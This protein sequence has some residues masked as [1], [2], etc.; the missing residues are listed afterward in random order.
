MSHLLANLN[1]RQ[2]E[3]VMIDGGPALILAGPGSG[4]TRVLTHRIA[5]LIHQLNVDPRSIMAVTFTNKAATEMRDR[6][7][8]LL[9]QPIK[10]LVT[11]G[12]FHAICARILRREGQY[13]PFGDRY[14][15]YDT[16]D[17][18]AVVKQA[19]SE[20]NVDPKK[21]TPRQVLGKIS[22]AKNELITPAMFKTLDY[23][24]EVVKQVYTRYQAI[25]LDNNA[26]DFDDLLMQTV[27]LLQDDESIRYKYQMLVQYLLI[28]EFQDTNVAQYEF[29]RLMGAPQQNIFV[30]GDEDQ[31]VYAFRGADYRNV[32]RFRADYPDAQVVLLEQN[33][34]STQIVLDAAR[35]VI[36]RNPNRTPKR[37][38]TDREGGAQI[39]VFEAYNERMEAEYITEQIDRLARRQK[40]NY[41]DFAVMYRT[42]AQSRAI[43]TAFVQQG[44]PYRMV[45]GVGF[46][47][48]REVRDLIAYLRVVDNANDKVSFARIINVPRRSIG[49]K[50]LHDFQMWASSEGGNYQA[51]LIRVMNGESPLSTRLVRPLSEFTAQLIKWQALAGDGRLLDCLDAIIGDI[52]YRWYLQEI[53]DSDEQAIDRGENVDELRGLLKKA[54]EANISLTEFLADQSLVSD[55]DDLSEDADAVTLLTLHAAKGLE[56][57]IVFITGMEEGMLPHMRSFEDPDSMEEERRLMY[58]GM[59]RAEDELHLTYAFRRSLWGSELTNAPSR[60]LSDLPQEVLQDVPLGLREINNQRGYKAQTRWET[61]PVSPKAE[62][63]G[64]GFTRDETPEKKKPSVPSA[65]SVSSTRPAT[66]PS[67]TP[68][69]S[70]SGK[71]RS[72]IVP[73][74]RQSRQQEGTFR[75]NDRVKH[76]SFG[77]GTVLE[78]KIE[79]GIELVTV[80]F[81]GQGF[82]T[83]EADYLSKLS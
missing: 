61:Q 35:A 73:F 53:S 41:R 22:D 37:L 82:K 38:F 59:T 46:Y 79:G 69:S 19:L 20:L 30:V 51:A 54:E 1:E 29:M 3:A 27:F 76:P 68:T 45:G 8:T 26:L 23:M 13:T 40:R 64:G 33:Y 52:G 5:Y 17:Q 14:H 48:R 65:P 83:L 7:E 71:L 12:T 80:V 47:K 36:E 2:R 78:S 56:Y 66:P 21:F 67:S 63:W 44:I 24:G 60:F 39:S 58:V 18:E 34:R 70:T 81:N 31:G 15:I 11:L 6:T 50:S 25:M 42:N 49:E 62:K 57:P 75:V 10:G 74:P 32:R 28:D 43:E 55:L 72:K 77:E 9:R 4:K 16:G